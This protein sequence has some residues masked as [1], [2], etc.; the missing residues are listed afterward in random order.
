MSELINNSRHRKDQL[1]KLI[2]KLHEGESP[3]LV[4]QQLVESLKNIP[5]GAIAFWTKG[6]F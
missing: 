3:A 2:L 5:Y 4:K 6:V 1:K